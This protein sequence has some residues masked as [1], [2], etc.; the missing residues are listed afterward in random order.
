MMTW[1]AGRSDREK[2]MI[3]SA[4][5]LTIIFVLYFLVLTPLLEEREDARRDYRRMA[6]DAS[7]VFSGLSMMQTFD[8]ESNRAVQGQ[9]ESLELLLSRTA[10]ARGL[11]IIR[12]QPSASGGLTVWFDAANPQTLMTW[13]TELEQQYAVLVQ[14]ADLRKRPEGGGLRGNVEMMRVAAS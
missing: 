5:G 8:T 2:L 4:G 3:L 14:R 12:L 11:E 9:N 7:Q 6:G 1:W 13:L 10:G